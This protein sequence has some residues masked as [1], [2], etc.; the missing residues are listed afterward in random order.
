MGFAWSGD[1]SNTI[2]PEGLELDSGPIKKPISAASASVNASRFLSWLLLAP[3][4]VKYVVS[5]SATASRSVVGVPVR[6]MD[7]VAAWPTTL[8]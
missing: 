7:S 6:V 3:G 2:V 1:V 4:T 8:Q 5:C